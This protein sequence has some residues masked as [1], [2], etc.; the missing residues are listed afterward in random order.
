[1]EPVEEKEYK[2]PVT[3]ETIQTYPSEED[4][5]KLLTEARKSGPHWD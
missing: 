4:W 5:A 1:M 3:G 2:S